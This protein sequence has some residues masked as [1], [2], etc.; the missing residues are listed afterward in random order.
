MSCSSSRRPV[1]GGSSSR[2]ASPDACSSRSLTVTGSRSAPRQSS[3]NADTRSS[4]SR[5]PVRTSSITTVVVATTFV[6]DARSNGVL[7]LAGGEDTSKVSVPTA[8]DHSAEAPFPTS[9][10]A[11]GNTRARIA[12]TTTRRAASGLVIRAWGVKG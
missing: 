1:G 12:S 2:A 9:I 5:A 7:T 4:K 3:K 8:S 11:A 6:S 10:A